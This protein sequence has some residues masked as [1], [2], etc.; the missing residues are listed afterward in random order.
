MSASSIL[1]PHHGGRN[2]HRSGNPGANTTN[3]E[4]TYA[5]VCL[6][7]GWE[8]RLTPQERVSLF[9]RT[10]DAHDNVER[11]VTEFRVRICR[12]EQRA[13]QPRRIR[14]P[15]PPAGKF[16]RHPRGVGTSSTIAR[17]LLP[18]TIR[19]CRQW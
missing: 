7:L 16:A 11:S 1:L 18:E 17:A 15:F 2:N 4:G 6:Q 19:G 10:S 5:D 3:S 13:H 8:E 9:C 12:L 14:A